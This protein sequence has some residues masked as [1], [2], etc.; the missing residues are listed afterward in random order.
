MLI[1]KIDLRSIQ[2]KVSSLH[3]VDTKVPLKNKLFAK[4]KY[5]QRANEMAFSN[6]VL[7]N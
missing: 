5:F 4:T 1:N 3:A 6:L 7:L 2:S